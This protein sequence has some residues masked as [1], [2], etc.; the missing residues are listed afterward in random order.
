LGS[1]EAR[2]RNEL[3]QCDDLLGRIERRQITRILTCPLFLLR[4]GAV[5]CLMAAE[6]AMPVGWVGLVSQRDD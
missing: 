5:A 4:R 1:D 2:V 6:A 3:V